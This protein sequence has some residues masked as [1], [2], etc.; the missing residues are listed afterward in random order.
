MGLKPITPQ[1]VYLQ[2]MN[3]IRGLIEEGHYKP[4]DRLPSERLL[5]EQLAISRPSVREA[6]SALQAMGL[7]RI[8]AGGG[9]FVEGP[10]SEFVA[11]LLSKEDNPLELMEARLAIEPNV[12][13]L[14]AKKR[15]EGDLQALHSII[16]E[17]ANAL[18]TGVHPVEGDRQY[19]LAIVRA[20][21]NT[22]L[23]TSVAPIIDQMGRSIWHQVKDRGLSGAGLPA[24]YHEQHIELYE[25]IEKGDARKARAAMRQHVQNI[26][27]DLLGESEH[28]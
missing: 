24:K 19:H 1:K 23:Y 25:A 21:H 11:L 13:E 3:Q 8:K 28:S 22:T 18:A 12:A 10:R 17:M 15:T 6:L 9:A 7:I 16:Q 5:S 4:G 2:A 27:A 20:A 14:A 26:V